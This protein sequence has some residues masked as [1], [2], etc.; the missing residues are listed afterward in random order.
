VFIVVKFADKYKIRKK[1]ASGQAQLYLWMK[2][3]LP[4]SFMARLARDKTLERALKVAFYAYA[5]KYRLRERTAPFEGKVPYIVHPLRVAAISSILFKRHRIKGDAF[6]EGVLAAIFHDF[7][8]DSENKLLAKHS[9]MLSYGLDV[10][11][12]VDKLTFYPEK[13][14]P[15]CQVII[16]PVFPSMPYNTYA[17]YFLSVLND[18]FRVGA[19]KLADVVDNLSTNPSDSSLHK[20]LF[21]LEKAYLC[22]LQ[23]CFDKEWKSSRKARNLLSYLSKEYPSFFMFTHLSSK[24]IDNLILIASLWV[25]ILLSL[26]ACHESKNKTQYLT[27]LIRVYNYALINH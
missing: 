13:Q 26:K 20:Y 22:H 3:A 18:E 15:D 9:L 4:E 1:N 6:R 27:H 14:Y 8:E 17:N 2:E 5:D 21:A 23:P 12:M 19:I 10:A 25:D 16:S 24:E 11:D 7:I